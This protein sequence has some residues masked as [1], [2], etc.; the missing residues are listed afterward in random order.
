MVQKYVIDVQPADARAYARSLMPKKK[1]VSD[2]YPECFNEK[3]DQTKVKMEAI[4]RW[5]P[6]RISKLSYCKGKDDE[7]VH[8]YV[9]ALLENP[10]LNPR[11]LQKDLFGFLGINASVV[12]QE[13]WEMMLEGQT[14]DDGIPQKL[15]QAEAEVAAGPVT[16]ED[17]MSRIKAFSS[18]LNERVGTDQLV[19]QKELEKDL[20]RSAHRNNSSNGHEGRGRE[21]SHK[22]HK[23]HKKHKH[24][25]RDRRSDSRSRSPAR[26]RRRSRSPARDRRRSR[27]KGSPPRRAD[28]SRSPPRR[29][30]GSRSPPRRRASS[31]SPARR[32]RSQS[33]DQARE[34]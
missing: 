8:S 16:A 33:R 34:R 27:S 13:I 14:R 26:D 20:A 24:R 6:D 17:L 11:K 31:R 5:V 12:A 32:Q 2:G 1:A 30:D 10:E 21:T 7:V 15:Q 3:C 4:I 22:K 29:A 23:K 25:R 9:Q 28:A 18:E 19:P